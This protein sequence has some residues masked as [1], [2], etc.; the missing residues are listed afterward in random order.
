MNLLEVENL[1]LRFGGLTALEGVNFH[2]KKGEIVSIIGPNGAGKTS[3]FNAITGVYDPTEGDVRLLGKSLRRA[4]AG[5]V[6]V[7]MLVTALVIGLAFALLVFV[8]SLWEGTIVRHFVYKASF[9]WGDAIDSLVALFVATALPV[10]FAGVLLGGS[11]TFVVWS[12]TRWA[13]DAFALVGLSRTFQNI[14]LFSN[15]T[16]RE[17]ILVGMNRHIHTPFWKCLLI[18]LSLRHEEEAYN[19]R[20]FELLKF[21]GLDEVTEKKAS[22]LPYGYQRRLEIARALATEPLLLLLD[23][24]AAG[25]NPTEAQALMDL[26]TRIR[27]RGV[28]ILLIE[29]HM[30]VVM[31]ISDRVVVLNYGQKIAEGTPEKIRTNPKVIE[32]YLGGEEKLS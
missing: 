32:A 7:G 13:A 26:I 9:P 27:D 22:S 8:Q 23:E 5:K 25:T 12:R 11:A 10:F 31:G 4:M 6:A 18:P 3:L 14:R 21:V 24:P 1:T 17:N 30:K 20:A 29:H 2:V 15:M 19:S 28:T 16:V